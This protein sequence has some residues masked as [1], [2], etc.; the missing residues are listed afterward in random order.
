MTARHT[1][2]RLGGDKLALEL[3]GSQLL[4]LAR[5]LEGTAAALY[6]HA[7]LCGS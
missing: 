5:R 2:D 6:A 1:I 7:R 3:V 4:T